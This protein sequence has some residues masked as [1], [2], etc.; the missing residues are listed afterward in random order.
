[1]I[2]VTAVLLAFPGALAGGYLTGLADH[3][4]SRGALLRLVGAAA[5]PNASASLRI[6]VADPA[7]NRPL[8]LSVAGLPDVRRGY[9]E[10]FLV[11]HGTWR[12]CGG[13]FA[14][15]RSARTTVGLSLRY[16]LGAGD[17]WIVTQ[18]RPGLPDPGIAVLRG[19]M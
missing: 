2:L 4:S 5:A 9:Y 10:L 19:S 7:G 11:E 13:F 15:A 6:G 17:R 1:M 18:E 12:S 14:A 8:R 16:R 3:G